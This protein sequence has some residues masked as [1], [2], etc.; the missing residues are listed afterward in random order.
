VKDSRVMTIFLALL[1]IAGTLGGTLGGVWLGSYLE[2]D[3]DA[4]KWRREHALQAYSQ[5]VQA[6][7]VVRFEADRI[8]V[9]PCY[10]E[11]HI[12]QA[13][14]VLDKMA[15]MVLITHRIVLLAPESVNAELRALTDY[16]GHQFASRSIE[17]PKVE[18]SER[19]AL[20]IGLAERLVAFRTEARNDLDV[21]P[22]LHTIE[23]WNRKNAAKK[24]WWQ[25]WR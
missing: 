18:K 4:L 16:A 22:P 8:Y 23:E 19:S 17:C 12:K 1:A 6:V 3:S 20:M 13:R 7:D 2:R 9:G 24:P 14:V 11:E 15:E 25:I 21:H 10:T 5:L